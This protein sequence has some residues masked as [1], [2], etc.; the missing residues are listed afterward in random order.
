M[1]SLNGN[2]ES[3]A[4]YIEALAKCQPCT[5]AGQLDE[6]EP[7]QPSAL[8]LREENVAKVV[9]EGLVCVEFMPSDTMCVV[10]AGDKRGHVRSAL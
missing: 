4:A 5:S 10:A 7:L 1:V 8:T 3:D 9:K 6:A 2:D